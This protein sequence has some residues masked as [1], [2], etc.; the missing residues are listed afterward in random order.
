MEDKPQSLVQHLE[1]L[2]RRLF[3]SLIAIFLGFMICAPFARNIRA[4]LMEPLVAV[5]PPEM[6]KPVA[7]NIV[8]PVLLDLKLSLIVGIFVASPYVIYQIWAFVAPGLYA[9]EKKF[10]APLALVGAFFFIGGAA[11]GYFL[12]FPI[13]FKFLV[14]YMSVDLLPVLDIQENVMLAAKLLLGFGIIF[15][16]PV[17]IFLLALMGIVTPELLKKYR[18]YAIVSIFIIAAILTP[19]DVVSQ[20]LMAMPML[21]L[22]ELGV[23]AAKFVAKREKKPAEEQT[24]EKP[25]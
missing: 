19:P 13:V 24:E 1:E 21:V 25:Q 14:D 6:A 16:L 12:V 18:K 7:L 10:V 5:L 4:F 2:R 3:R 15:E 22:F 11:F 17:F 8:S 23:F 20:I 9:R